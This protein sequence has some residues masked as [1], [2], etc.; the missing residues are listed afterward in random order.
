MTAPIDHE[1]S[2][3]ASRALGGDRAAWDALIGR[4]DRRVLLTL[5]S[6]GVRADRAR[7]LTQETWARLV[8]HQQ[9]GRLP[10]LDLPGLAIRQAL[11]L[12]A[13]DARRGK[14]ALVGDDEL[15]LVRDPSPTIED[16]LASR[17]QLARASDELDRCPEKA[18]KVFEMVYEAPDIPHEEAARRVGL[19][20]QRLRQTLCE[21]RRRLRDVLDTD[22]PV[23]V[24]RTVP[25]NSDV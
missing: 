22:E 17:S 15:A 9:A 3:L 24:A 11:F 14:T 23:A 25:E 2:R 10:R 16:R 7:D 19:S 5:L 4:H 8:A 6:R 20:V 18:R 21:V 1:D 12:A 13:D